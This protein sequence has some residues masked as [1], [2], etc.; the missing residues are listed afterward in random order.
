MKGVVV[1]YASRGN[2]V[3]IK[4]YA[5][6]CQS[7]FYPQMGVRRVYV[8]APTKKWIKDNWVNIAG[9]TEYRIVRVDQVA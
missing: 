8:T 7:R 1:M 4:K 5:V 2:T 9:T 3:A 6:Y